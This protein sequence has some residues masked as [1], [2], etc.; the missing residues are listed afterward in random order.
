MT[1]T[2]L[3]DWLQYQLSFRSYTGKCIFRWSATGRG[4]RLH[5]TSL[6]GAVGNVR[7]AIINAIKEDNK[8]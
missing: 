1:D 2:E 8:K 7:E 4:W 5:E 3:L 6:K